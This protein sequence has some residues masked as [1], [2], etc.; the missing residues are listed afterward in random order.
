MKKIC[1]LLSLA[2]LFMVNQTYGQG[3]PGAPPPAT[4]VTKGWAS[5]ERASFISEC[6]RT[7]KASM[8]EDSARHYCYCMEEMME[9]KYPNSGDAGKIT[10]EELQS[11]EWKKLINNCLTESHWNT[12]NRESFLSDCVNSAKTN[13]GD[14]KAKSY[15]ECMLFKVEQ[16]YPNPQDAGKLTP[17]VLA[18][19]EW[20]RIVRGCLDF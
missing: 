18:S 20:K 11:P 1:M 15:C 2:P 5:S 16:H 19:P 3:D 6:T 8:S 9:I 4:T 14:T 7:A 13:L 10:K 17:E 12:K